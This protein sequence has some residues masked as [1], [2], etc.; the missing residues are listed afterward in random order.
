[1]KIL[2]FNASPRKERGTTNILL[3]TFIEGASETKAEIAKHHVVD[4]DINGCRGCFTCWWKT[5]GKC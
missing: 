4:L 1:M 3:D 5:P 2:V